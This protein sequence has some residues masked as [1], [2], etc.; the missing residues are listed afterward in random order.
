MPAGPASL[1]RQVTEAPAE[2]HGKTGETQGR[3]LGEEGSWAV[4]QTSMPGKFA[5]RSRTTVDYEVGGVK[6]VA[7]AFFSS[8]TRPAEKGTVPLS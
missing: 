5:F 6:S 3:S 7:A 4:R 8:F 1:I 2:Q